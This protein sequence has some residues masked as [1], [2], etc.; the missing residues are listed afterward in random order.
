MKTINKTQEAIKSD[1]N[2]EFGFMI[3][4][5]LKTYED[6]Y[7]EYIE[8]LKK[9]QTEGKIQDLVIT[10]TNISFNRL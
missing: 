5:G 4:A 1:I 2:F 8:S 7:N 9:F 3:D 10:D 6:A